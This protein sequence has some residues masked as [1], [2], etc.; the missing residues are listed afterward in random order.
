MPVLHTMSM[1]YARVRITTLWQAY[2]CGVCLFVFVH[3]CV[4][5]LC[6]WCV[7]ILWRYDIHS[8]MMWDVC[9][10]NVCSYIEVKI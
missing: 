4:R 10:W 7:L 6:L 8:H 9:E 2:V 1:F 5:A 3:A